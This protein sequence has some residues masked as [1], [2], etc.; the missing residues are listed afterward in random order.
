[1]PGPDIESVRRRQQAFREWARANEPKLGAIASDEDVLFAIMQHY[2]IPTDF[3]DFTTEPS[4]AGFFASDTRTEPEPCIYCISTQDLSRYWGVAQK[5]LEPGTQLRTVTL[6]VPN[7]WRLE[8]QHGVFLY[9]NYN[10]DLDYPPDR[11][12][13]PYTGYPIG[14]CIKNAID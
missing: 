10:W 6:Q 3:I 1:M 7:L 14:V 8:A 2:G 11:I 5:Y 4:I 13:F 12:V 9:A